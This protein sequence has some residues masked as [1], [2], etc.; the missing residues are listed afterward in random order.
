MKKYI[1]IAFICFS[2][3]SFQAKTV[4]EA[5]LSMPVD[6]LLDVSIENKMDLLDSFEAH[7]NAKVQNNLKEDVLIKD[8]SDN[9]FRLEMGNTNIQIIVLEMVNKSQLYCFIRTTCVPSCDSR[10]E[11]YSVDWS[12]LNTN[13]FISITPQTEFINKIDDYPLLKAIELMQFDYN[14]ENN[15]LSQKNNSLDILS[16]EDQKKIKPNI[17]KEVVEYKW[18]GVRFL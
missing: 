8:M 12:K 10:I 6:M 2:Y 11:F 3:L 9:Y 17:K 1:L 7:S 18:N 5:F 4:K 15:I 16:L 13:D 14:S